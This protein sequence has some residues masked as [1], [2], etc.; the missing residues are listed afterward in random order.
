VEVCK[1]FRLLVFNYLFA[2]G[3]AH[4]KNFSL[5]QSP[6]G[7]Y[8]LSPAYDLLNSALHISDE[9]FALAGGLFSKEYYSEVYQQKGHPCQDDFITLGK[10]INVPDSQVQK[11]LKDFTAPKPLVYT[12]TN[13]SFL[14]GRLQ[15]TYLRSYQERLSRLQRTTSPLIK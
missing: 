14:D 9:S 5:Q 3:D 15:R 1:F 2:N 11:I 8:L 6:N 10:I 12:L 7:D 4:L 13:R